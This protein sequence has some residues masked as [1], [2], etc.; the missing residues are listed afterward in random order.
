MKKTSLVSC[1]I[2]LMMAGQAMAWPPERVVIEP[3]NPTSA[4]VVVITLSGEWHGCESP[5][6]SLIHV[7]G[8]KI[9]FDVVA[10]EGL[11]ICPA[12]LPWEFTESV[13]PLPAGTYTVYAGV[14]E[15]AISEPEPAACLHMDA[16]TVVV[17]FVVSDGAA[18]SDGDGMPDDIDNC[19]HDYNPDQADSDGDGVGDACDCMCPGDINADGQVDLRDLDAMI[20]LLVNAGPPYLLYVQDWRSHCGN[21]DGNGQLDLQDLDAMVQLLVNAGPPFIVP[22]ASHEPSITLEIYSG[23]YP[24][25]LLDKITMAGQGEITI[26][27]EGASHYYIYALREG[28][29]TE[30]YYC[31]K[32]ETIDVD[33]DRI[34]PGRF[35]GVIFISDL[36]VEDRYLENSDVKVMAGGTVVA[37]FRT[38]GQGRFVIELEP[39]NYYFEFT[40]YGLTFLEE[41]EIRGGYQDFVFPCDIGVDKPN[42][43]LY[44]EET[45]ELDVDIVFPHGG[46]VTRSIPDYGDG[47]HITAEPTGVIDGEYECLFYEASVPD[48]GQYAAGWVVGREELEDFFSDNMA[49]TG[50]IQKEIDDFIE[51]W[52]PR[53]VEYPYYAIYPQYNEELEDM[54][55]LEFSTPPTSVIRLIYS[56]RGLEKN[57]LRILEP[58][59]PAFEREGFTVTEWGVIRK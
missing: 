48:W 57:T 14:V 45:I 38:D 22:C 16:P 51:Y 40:W 36:V 9:Y 49:Q 29:Y 59:I 8:K 13:G 50:F 43:Y 58:V 47:W 34:V 24:K 20:N 44:P 52:I 27:V 15:C 41:A 32:S 55:R 39:G 10:P 31:H 6:D 56:V 19:P 54:I 4:D 12:I 18:D 30:L 17:E 7:E 37:Q 2:F 26:S 46:R 21:F 25:A 53:L 1:V 5:E 28:Y 11:N 42:I 3:E 33:L 23:D 35:N